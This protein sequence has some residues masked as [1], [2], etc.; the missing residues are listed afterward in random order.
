MPNEAT[1]IFA[2]ISVVVFPIITGYLLSRWKT[3][4]Q[5]QYSLKFSLWPTVLF[6]FKLGPEIARFLFGLD[7]NFSNIFNSIIA[8]SIVF[9]PIFFVIGMFKYS[10][11]KNIKNIKNIKNNDS[12]DMFK[13]SGCGYSVNINDHNNSNLLCPECNCRLVN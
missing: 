3:A 4:T 12:V 13:C 2:G 1:V 5:I 7:F 11:K 8:P 10:D 6:S 9:C